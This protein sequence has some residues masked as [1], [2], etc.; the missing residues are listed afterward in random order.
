MGF[1]GTSAQESP[2]EICRTT[3]KKFP[4]VNR[5]RAVTNEKMSSASLVMT[6][7]VSRLRLTQMI[8]PCQDMSGNWRKLASTF[9]SRH[10]KAG[11]N[12]IQEWI[13]K[14]SIMCRTKDCNCIM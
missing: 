10:L 12:R 14:M 7:Q 13:K 8:Q 3:W 1:V 5:L 4:K 6:N 2:K 11:P 9:L